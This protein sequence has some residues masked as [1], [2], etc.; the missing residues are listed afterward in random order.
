MLD[1][2]D[3]LGISPIF[4]VED[5]ILHRGTFE[6]PSL[7]FG[8]SAGTQVPKLP[9]FPQLHTDIEVALDDEFVSPL[10]AVSIASWYNGLAAHMMP[11][12]L[13]KMSYVNLTLH[14]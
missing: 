14:C 12:G 11:L 10:V 13:Q 7:P 5:L 1:L 8:D 2:P 3:N 4:N 6:H 9:T